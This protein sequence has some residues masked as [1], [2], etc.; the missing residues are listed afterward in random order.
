MKRAVKL[1]VPEELRPCLRSGHPGHHHAR[2]VP[3]ALRQ[4]LATAQRGRGLSG[5]NAQPLAGATP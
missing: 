2:R 4:R 1:L 3:A 5:R